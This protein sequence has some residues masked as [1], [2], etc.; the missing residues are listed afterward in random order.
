MA[1]Q[2]LFESTNSA[3]REAGV[4]FNN[5]STLPATSFKYPEPPEERALLACEIDLAI[6]EYAPAGWKGDQARE[7]Q[8]LNVLFPLLGRDREATMALF[9]IIKNQPG[10]K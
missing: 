6:R 1:F 2:D 3:K 8:V 7:A 5:L 10:Y 4:L 9:E